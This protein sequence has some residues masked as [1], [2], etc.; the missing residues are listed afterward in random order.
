MTTS[1]LETQQIESYLLGTASG[2]DRALFAAR[3]LLEPELKANT[4]RQESAYAVINEYGR[5]K[6]RQ[7]IEEV[8]RILFTTTKYQAFSRMILGIFRK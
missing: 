6:L 5:Q 4:S 1:W 8:S 7:E 3:L 2:E